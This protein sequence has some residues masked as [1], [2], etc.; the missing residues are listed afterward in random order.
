MSTLRTKLAS[1]PA[2]HWLM[3]DG[4]NAA[5][6]LMSGITR[7]GIRQDGLLRAVYEDGE[8]KEIACPARILD[9]PSEAFTLLA[10]ASAMSDEDA[11]E[12]PLRSGGDSPSYRS[13]MRDAGRGHLLP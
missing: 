9:A 3:I 4:N 8:E 12:E 10:V 1:I 13:Q 11:P 5:Q 2:D 7:A 6:H